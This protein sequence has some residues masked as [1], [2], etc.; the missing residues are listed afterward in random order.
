MNA[1]SPPT[2]SRPWVWDLTAVD[3][4]PVMVCASDKFNYI[5]AK[6]KVW[7]ASDRLTLKEYEKIVGILRWLSA[8]YRVGRAHLGYLMAECTQ[9]ARAAET[10]SSRYVGPPWLLSFAVGMMAK[11]AIG[12][13]ARF[14]PK[15]DGRCPVFLDFS[16]APRLHGKRSDVS[17][18]G[19]TG[20]GAAE[21]GSGSR[22]NLALM[23]IA[24]WLS[25]HSLVSG[26]YLFMLCFLSL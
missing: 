3:D 4:P 25:P 11:Q 16:S 12:F 22:V 8:G 21:A 9:H 1:M 5:K 10:P 14:F 2:C 20:L 7:T 26:S 13:W 19:P 17:T 24:S 18:T 23:V 6:L 15:W